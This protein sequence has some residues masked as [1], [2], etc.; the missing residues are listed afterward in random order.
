MVFG[1][2]MKVTHLT[3]FKL[4]TSK[5]DYIFILKAPAVTLNP[6]PNEVMSVKYVSKEE[7]KDLFATA[8]TCFHS[9]R[10]RTHLGRRQGIQNHALVQANRRELSI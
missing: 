7:L 6:S 4:L 9:Q 5:V 1:E 3:F 2:S 10:S 8:G